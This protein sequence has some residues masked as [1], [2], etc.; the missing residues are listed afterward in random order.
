MQLKVCIWYPEVTKVKS[1]FQVF[2]KKDDN[3]RRMSCM[4][5][6]YVIKDICCEERMACKTL[7]GF[8]F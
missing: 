1:W 5:W 7:R 8:R 3:I 2:V 4:D 6:M